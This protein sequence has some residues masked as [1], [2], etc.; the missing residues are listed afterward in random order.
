VK[1]LSFYYHSS[2]LEPTV[3]V[4]YLVLAFEGNPIMHCDIK[5]LWMVERIIIICPLLFKSLGLVGFLQ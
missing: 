4:T 1:E 2:V 5:S 3:V